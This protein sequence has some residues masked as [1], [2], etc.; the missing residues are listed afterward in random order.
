MAFSNFDVLI[1][2]KCNDVSIKVLGGLHHIKSGK[3][4]IPAKHVCQ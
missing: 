4:N 3:E 1:K 2:K